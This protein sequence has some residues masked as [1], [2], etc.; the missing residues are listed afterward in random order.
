MG[1]DSSA[2]AAF[3]PDILGSVGVGHEGGADNVAMYS[4]R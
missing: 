1:Q 4:P 3:R 2:W